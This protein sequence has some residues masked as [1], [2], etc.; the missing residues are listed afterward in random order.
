MKSTWFPPYDPWFA[1]GYLNYY[2]WGFVIVGSLIKLTGILPWIAYNLAIPTIAALAG[3]SLASVTYNILVARP[4]V[5]LRRQLWAFGGGVAAVLLGIVLG[6][7]HA[8]QQFLSWLTRLDTAPVQTGIPGVVGVTSVVRGLW[9]WVTSMG[10]NLPP[11]T[12]D[13][14][15]PTRVITTD[16]TT[17]ITEFPYFTFLYG[18]LHAHMIAM[19]LGLLAVALALNLVGNRPGCRA[20]RIVPRRMWPATSG[21]RCEHRGAS[22]WAWP[23]STSESHAWRTPGTS[24]P[25]WA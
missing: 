16:S 20:S 17:P 25:T 14:W 13:F 1:G 2:Y 21:W 12:Y 6:N 7:L 10:H 23:R 18:D 4:D 22:P 8:P 15:G 9:I 5:P 19:P 24:R 3:T 11:F